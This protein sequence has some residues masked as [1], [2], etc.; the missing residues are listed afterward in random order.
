MVNLT[1]RSEVIRSAMSLTDGEAKLKLVIQ[2]LYK[3]TGKPFSNANTFVLKQKE[4]NF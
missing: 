1:A 3:E 2:N 4:C